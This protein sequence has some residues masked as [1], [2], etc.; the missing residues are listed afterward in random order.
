M[1]IISIDSSS[2]KC[3]RSLVIYTSILWQDT[4]GEKISAIRWK[5][6]K[7]AAVVIQF[8]KPVTIRKGVTSRNQNMVIESIEAEFDAAGP[9]VFSYT[10][11]SSR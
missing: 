9:E 6:A 2:F 11:S 1:L 3:L 10:I 7:N 5:N 4:T 8:S